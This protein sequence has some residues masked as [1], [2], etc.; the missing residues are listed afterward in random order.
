MF[1]Y[2]ITFRIPIVVFENDFLGMNISTA[3]MYDYKITHED[4]DI[5][6]LHL[7]KLRLRAISEPKEYA[8]SIEYFLDVA[9]SEILVEFKSLSK[10]LD[11]NTLLEGALGSISTIVLGSN[12]KRII[13]LDAEKAVFD[14]FLPFSTQS[15]PY[16]WMVV[17]LYDELNLTAYLEEEISKNIGTRTKVHLVS[18]VITVSIMYKPLV[19]P[20]VRR[21]IEYALEKD[22]FYSLIGNRKFTLLP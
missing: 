17:T 20:D 4:I 14:C 22:S 11:R 3:V 13:V 1:T 21:A 7:N 19:D 16:Q 12:S 8:Y 9:G 15:F 6:H 18:G 2:T 5:I 10:Y